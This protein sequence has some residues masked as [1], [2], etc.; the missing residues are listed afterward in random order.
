MGSGKT[1]VGKQLARALQ[2]PFLD[3]D[4]EIE[5]RTGVDIPLIFDK[6][7]EAGFRQRE[8]EAI[9]EL[10]ARSGIVLSTGGG[11]IL[12]PENR[13]VLRARGVVVYLDT[14]VRQQLQRVRHGE[15]RPLLADARDLAARLEELM[16]HRAPLYTETAHVTVRTDGNRVQAVVGEILQKLP[17]AMQSAGI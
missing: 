9:A 14:S 16:Q 3:S 11:A 13:Q 15:N 10:A 17:G 6:E 2:L 7:G 5:R 4:H 8:R 12:L 1:A